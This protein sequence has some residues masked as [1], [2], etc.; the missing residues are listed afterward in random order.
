MNNTGDA[1]DDASRD[2]RDKISPLR[3]DM[4]FSGSRPPSMSPFNEDLQDPVDKSLPL[5][6]EPILLTQH[7][8]PR[9]PPSAS[10]SMWSRYTTGDTARTAAEAIPIHTTSPATG[11]ILFGIYFYFQSQSGA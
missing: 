4:D 11:V 1:F 8:G 10:G 6:Q 7:R 9:V 5:A 2:P 3:H